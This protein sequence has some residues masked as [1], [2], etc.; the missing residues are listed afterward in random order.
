MKLSFTTSILLFAIRMGSIKAKA[1]DSS[2][3]APSIFKNG[4][5]VAS[6]AS[7]GGWWCSYMG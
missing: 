1:L 4:A 3:D 6:D 7:A 2:E 5:I